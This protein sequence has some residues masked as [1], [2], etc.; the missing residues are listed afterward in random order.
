M[1]DT[2]AIFSPKAKR[3]LGFALSE[4]AMICT[5]QRDAL[6]P[7]DDVFVQLDND[8]AYIR[9]LADWIHGMPTLERSAESVEQ[10]PDV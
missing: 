2:P 8:V 4:W 6:S 5:I 9:E 1:S 10:A 3:T 7:D